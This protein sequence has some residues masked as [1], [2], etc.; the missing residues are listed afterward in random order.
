ME[1]DV[2]FQL[3]RLVAHSGE[4]ATARLELTF[5]EVGLECGMRLMTCLMLVAEERVDA[6]DKL[7]ELAEQ[8]LA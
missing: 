2:A 7:S 1:L 4:R 5:E 8:V 3:E 6:L